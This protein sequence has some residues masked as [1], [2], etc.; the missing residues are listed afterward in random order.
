MIRRVVAQSLLSAMLVMAEGG[1]E[2][3]DKRQTRPDPRPTPAVTPE[4]APPSSTC[5]ARFADLP[6]S[7]PRSER[8]CNCPVSALAGRVWGSG[9]YTP[10]SAV[11]ASAVHAGAITRAGGW[12]T[13]RSAAGCATYLGTTNNGVTTSPTN[14]REQ[15]FFFPSVGDGK[16]GVE[17]T[18]S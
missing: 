13:L 10:D 12:I 8:T 3:S 9:I 18:G 2:S 14:A 15:S 6:A 5:P 1:C 4:L 11:C 7:D 16:C 17:P